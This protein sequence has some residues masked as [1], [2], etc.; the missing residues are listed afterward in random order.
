MVCASRFPIKTNFISDETSNIIETTN[1]KNR[2]D[3]R[4]KNVGI[5]QSNTRTEEKRA[6]KPNPKYL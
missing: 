4:L 6:R 5:E 3:R 2:I 1:K